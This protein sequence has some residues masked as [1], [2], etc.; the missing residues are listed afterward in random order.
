[1]RQMEEKHPVT[2]FSPATNEMWQW[3]SEAYQ[4]GDVN[5]KTTW[6]NRSLFQEGSEMWPIGVKKGLELRWKEK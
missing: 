2:V 6:H 5:Q 1:M 3:D 4:G